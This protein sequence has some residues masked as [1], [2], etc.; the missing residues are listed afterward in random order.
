MVVAGIVAFHVL[1][2][3]LALCVVGRVVPEEVVGDILGYIHKTIGI[4]IPSVEMT[5]GIAL[6]WLGSTVIIV[7]GC[8]LLLFFITSLT[9]TSLTNSR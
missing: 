4:T 8:V 9:N 1:M 3:L 2:L 7:D 5:R 6:I